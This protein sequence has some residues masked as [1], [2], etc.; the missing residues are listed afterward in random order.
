MKA[1]MDSATTIGLYAA[2]CKELNLPFVF[3]GTSKS[4]ET[5]L[6]FCSSDQLSAAFVFTSTSSSPLVQ[7]Q[8]LNV[9][10]GDII[11]WV[12][13]W[14]KVASYFNLEP[15]QPSESRKM[16]LT[17]MFGNPESEQNWDR[18]IQ[19]YGL[20]EIKLSEVATW[21]YVDWSLSREYHCITDMSKAREAGFLQY[22]NTEKDFLAVFDE[23]KRNKIIP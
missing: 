18:I 13:L 3:P 16:S 17:D 6:D 23:M 2:L 22:R 15:V 4:Y 14:P 19:K 20:K 10:N 12:D 8:A 5:L 11:R 21:Q 1:A 7:D 9:V